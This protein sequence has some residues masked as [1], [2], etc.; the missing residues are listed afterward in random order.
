M[1]PERWKKIETI[2]QEAITLR[3][4]ERTTFIMNS[5]AGDDELMEE[6][7]SLLDQ[8]ADSTLLEEPLVEFQSSFLFSNDEKLSEKTIGPYKL[9]RLIGSGGMGKVYL[10]ARNDEHFERFVALKIIKEGIVSDDVLS[11]FVGE[12]QILASLNHPNIARLFDGG[13]TDSGLPWFAMEYVEGTPITDY[14]NSHNLSVNEKLDLFLKVCSA[15]Q[16]A[17]QNLVIH[18]DLKPANIL[19]TEKSTPK[20]LDFGIAKLI[21]IDQKPGVTQY[22]NRLMTPEYASPEQAKHEPVSTVSDVYSLGI[23]LFEL[24]TGKL[25][26]QFEKR[27]PGYIESVICSKEPEEPSQVSGSNQLKGD[28]DN[29][30]LKALKKNPRERYSSVEQFAD[31]IRRHQKALPVLARK[32]SFP[33]R[34]KKFLRRHKWSVSVTMAITFL[35]LSFATV[36]YFQSKAIEAR[37]IEAETERDRAEEV[38]NFLIDLFESVDPSEAQDES[39]SAVELLK[40]GA[41]RVE[42]EL[43]GQPDLQSE[44]YQVISDVY[45]SLGMYDDGIEMAEIALSI[46]RDLYGEIHPDIATSINSLGWLHHQK[47]EYQTADSLLNAALRMRMHLYDEDHLDIART[48]NDLAVLKQTLGEYTATDTLL[49]RALEIRR[50][51]L[52]DNHE[53]VGVALS[54]YAALKWRLGDLEAAEEMMRET[55]SILKSNESEENMRVSIAM[56]NLAAILLTQGDMEGAEPLYRKALDVRLKLVG[57]EHPDVAYSYAHLG[58]LLR[59]K[60]DYEEA[61]EHLLKALELRKKLLG[62][63]HILVG[64]TYRLLGYLHFFQ[65]NYEQSVE[66]FSQGEK[67]FK[68]VFPNGHVRTAEIQHLLGETHLKMSRPDLAEPLFRNAMEIREQFFGKEDERTIRSTIYLGV[69]LF[70]N[71]KRLQSKELLE[72]GTEA[73][74]QTDLQDEGLKSLADETLAEL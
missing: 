55:L 16:Y 6:V 42:N 34:S 53:S 65:G 61:N 5:C 4:E 51:L 72:I 69:S 9:I 19:I 64:D 26:Y 47:G 12:R 11:R 36:T 62:E 7:M 31:D 68:G 33:Y 40:R 59:L 22:Q 14:C 73:M 25:P 43:R 10:A 60:G 39:L 3:G 37:A 41:D 57:E 13:T 52:G 58:N 1:T 20:L 35:I 8:E 66:Y 56:T 15:V 50:N 32:D 38:S 24:L 18:R 63:D 17:H 28:L 45:E 23:L 49:L 67:T 29:I 44:L 21:Q 70:Q 30:I 27:S 48:L 74:N 2:C 46:Q 71:G 54:N